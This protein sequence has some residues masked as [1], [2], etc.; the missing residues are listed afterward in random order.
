MG[1]GSDA[2]KTSCTPVFP[3]QR[4]VCRSKNAHSTAMS[5]YSSV[6]NCLDHWLDFRLLRDGYRMSCI[7]SVMVGI[8]WLV[9]GLLLRMA[10]LRKL[11]EHAWWFGLVTCLGRCSRLAATRRQITRPRSF[12]IRCRQRRFLSPPRDGVM[13][14][15]LK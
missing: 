12:Q 6:W 15:L 5:H 8:Y 13:Q 9:P 11:S 2:A 7:G 14:S 1:P 10:Y 3:S 4:P